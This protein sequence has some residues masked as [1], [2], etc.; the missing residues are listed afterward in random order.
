MKS[1]GRAVLNKTAKRKTLARGGTSY[2]SSTPAREAEPWPQGH[3]EIQ[4][5]TPVYVAG[6]DSVDPA[7][8]V[9]GFLRGF[10]QGFLPGP[11]AGPPGASGDE[12]DDDGDVPDHQ[13]GVP[14]ID[15]ADDVVAMHAHAD[16]AEGQREDFGARDAHGW[17]HA[18]GQKS[19][20]HRAGL[21]RPNLEAHDGGQEIQDLQTEEGEYQHKLL[22]GRG[23]ARVKTLL[24]G[25]MPGYNL[26]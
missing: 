13:G 12:P 9:P 15:P 19:P 3:E 1:A 10:V 16:P 24:G 4:G 26:R 22:I 17:G 20:D 5:D 18:Q 6:T 7:R 14:V 11:S 2:E 8:S 25:P 23:R 21:R